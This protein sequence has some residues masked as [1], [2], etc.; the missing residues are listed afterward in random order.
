MVGAA[1]ACDLADITSVGVD[2]SK[3]VAAQTQSMASCTAFITGTVMNAADMEDFSDVMNVKDQFCVATNDCSKYLDALLNKVDEL[4][5]KYPKCHEKIVT[6]INGAVALSG[7]TQTD[8][9]A[10]LRAAKKSVCELSCG[11]KDAACWTC[12]GSELIGTMSP[13]LSFCDKVPFCKKEGTAGCAVDTSKKCSGSNTLKIFKDKISMVADKCGNIKDIIKDTGAVACTS[14]C[15]DA[16]IQVQAFSKKVITD[17]KAN[18]GAL[19]KEMAT[20][21]VLCLMEA[22]GSGDLKDKIP[23]FGDILFSL[24]GATKPAQKQLL[25]KCKVTEAEVTTAEA[26]VAA[27]ITTAVAADEKAAAGE[28]G[29]A[30]FAPHVALALAGAAA[31]LV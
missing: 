23:D 22:A 19:A 26:Q 11:P 27:S 6:T 4:E 16:V 1:A 13:A 21:A 5:T 2:L 20:N 25:D 15:K 24:N 8:V 17:A 12:E 7:F 31:L 9:V 10:T 30:S 3:F 29:A 14:E 18:D 28:S